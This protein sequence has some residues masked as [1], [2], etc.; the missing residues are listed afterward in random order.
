MKKVLLTDWKRFELINL[1]FLITNRFKE[2]G[3]APKL[4][5]AYKLKRLKEII[6]FSE[7]ELADFEGKPLTEVKEVMENISKE[8]EV[9]SFTMEELSSFYINDDEIDILETLK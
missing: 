4:P 3:E 1:L 6:K 8:Y 9:P 5:V 7:E 2:K